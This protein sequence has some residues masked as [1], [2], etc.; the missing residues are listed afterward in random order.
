VP[1]QKFLRVLRALSQE[2]AEVLAQRQRSA[3]WVDKA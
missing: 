2:P 1:Q 3:F